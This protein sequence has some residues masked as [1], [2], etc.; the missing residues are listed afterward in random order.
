MSSP[1]PE[2]ASVLPPTEP[3]GAMGAL[4]DH[5][6]AEAQAIADDQWD[7]P[8]PW[9]PQ[10][11]VADLVSHLGGLQSA[12]NG[13]PQPEPPHGFQP[14]PDVDRFTAA[15]E[16]GIAARRDWTPQQRLDEL[17]DASDAHVAVLAAV[18]DWTEPTVG[19]TG[20]TTQLGLY[21]ARA[22]DVWVHLQD[23]REALGHPVDTDDRSPAAAAAYLFVLNVVP[24]MFVKRAGAGEGATMRVTLGP[25]LEHDN[26]LKV[27]DGRAAWD[28]QADPGDC[29]VAGTP[30]ALTLLV[31]GRGSADRWRD[32][33]VLRWA[34]P[35]GEDFVERAGMF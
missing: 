17:R 26:V 27:V 11:R 20:P 31:A 35:R 30:A 25:P 22:F 19:P 21:A 34:G 1:L 24:W 6:V 9:C 32:A 16:P 33:G 2:G 23:L 28:P 5:A 12:L 18:E 13:A 29:Y 15:M 3:P 8:V 4:W 7:L 14:S 10:W